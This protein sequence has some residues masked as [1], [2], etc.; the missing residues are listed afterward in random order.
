MNS[1]SVVIVFEVQQLARFGCEFLEELDNPEDEHY[2]ASYWRTSWGFHFTVPE[3]GPDRL[4]PEQ[5]LFAIMAELA[6]QQ[7]G[8]NPISA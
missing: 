1:I 6:E 8:G 2:R 5:N 7:P 3:L 4:C